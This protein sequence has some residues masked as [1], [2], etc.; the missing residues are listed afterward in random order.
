MGRTRKVIFV[1]GEALF[2][3]G[4]FLLGLLGGG[5]EEK[6]GM[7]EM[8]QTGI[9]CGLAI[10]IMPWLM[11]L[12]VRFDIAI[13]FFKPPWERPRLFRIPGG[14]DDPLPYFQLIAFVFAAM[15]V[16]AAVSITWRGLRAVPMALLGICGGIGLHLGLKRL[17]ARFTRPNP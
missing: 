10:L 7:S 12:L 17:T 3:L 14:W 4:G 8:V 13:G 15:G 11:V 6:A 9:A 2:L 1:G 16:G 5:Q